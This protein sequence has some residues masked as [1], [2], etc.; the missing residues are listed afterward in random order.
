MPEQL[1]APPTATA[2]DW[3]ALEQ[4]WQEQ[5]RRLQLARVAHSYIGGYKALNDFATVGIDSLVGGLRWNAP[6]TGFGLDPKSM[7]PYG[8]MQYWA[9][10]RVLSCATASLL[11]PAG[12][13]HDRWI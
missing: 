1:D 8:W 7:L 5:E 4:F 10:A 3:S 13:A 9:T 12:L 11:M 6:T 2:L